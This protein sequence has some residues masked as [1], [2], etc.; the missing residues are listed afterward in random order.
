MPDATA[1]E[2]L[3]AIEA[4]KRLK[5]RYCRCLD[6][7]DWAGFLAVFTPDAVV[8]TSEAFT[9]KDHA[10]AL[11]IIDGV[12]PPAPNPAGRS[13]DSAIFVADV[14]KM[15]DGVSTVHHC[16]TPEIELTSPTRATGIWA[17]EDKLRW[18]RGSPIRDMHGYGHY[19]ETYEL[20]PQGWRIKTLKLTRLR[21]DSNS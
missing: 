11:L 21:V 15:L 12:V 14:G 7:K 2:Q 13:D 19:R 20:L 6:T 4:I 3:L 9:P 8:D 17:M 1:S 16:H 18:P 10:G 5:A